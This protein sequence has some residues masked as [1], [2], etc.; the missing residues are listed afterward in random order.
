MTVVGSRE[1]LDPTYRVSSSPCETRRMTVVGSREEL[2]PTYRV[3]SSPCETRRTTVV[4]SREELDP[5]YR[6]SSSPCETHRMTVVGSREELDPTYRVSLSS[7]A[8]VRS[9]PGAGAAVAPRPQN[10][11][12][13]CCRQELGSFGTMAL[14]AGIGHPDCMGSFRENFSGAA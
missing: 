8:R 14:L 4:G 5:T 11:N 2:D 13:L 12:S 10:D 9:T 6:V 3:S 1:E 7:L